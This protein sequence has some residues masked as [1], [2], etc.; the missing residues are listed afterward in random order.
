MWQVLDT[1]E[2]CRGLIPATHVLGAFKK[3]VPKRESKEQSCDAPAASRVKNSPA[4]C[5][6]RWDDRNTSHAN[7]AGCM[8]PVYSNIYGWGALAEKQS[9]WISTTCCGDFQPKILSK[10]NSRPKQ[11]LYIRKVLASQRGE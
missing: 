7:H 9:W 6:Q 4:E 11:Q 2:A 5:G 10:K 1:P 8:Q 3:E